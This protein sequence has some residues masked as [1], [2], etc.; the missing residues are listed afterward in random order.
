MLSMAETYLWLRDGTGIGSTRWKHVPEVDAAATWRVARSV[1]SN[2]LGM[3]FEIENEFEG[4]LGAPIDDVAQEAIDA[5]AVTY[6][7]DAGIDV[8][9]HLRAQLASRGIK[10]ADEESVAE[11]AHEIRSGHHVNVGRPDGSMEERAD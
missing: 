10:A 5:T 9:E 3:K 11:I 4:E 7:S 2:I 8:E 1:R 6:T